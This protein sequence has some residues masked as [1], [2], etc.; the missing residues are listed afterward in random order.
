RSS[1]LVAV[2]AGFRNIKHH[3]LWIFVLEFGIAAAGFTK[4]K[5]E[6]SARLLDTLA[7]C[8]GVVHNKTKVMRT[9]KISTLQFQERQI[10]H[11]IGQIHSRACIQR[12]FAHFLEP[13][14]LLVELGSGFKVWDA[15]RNVTEFC[16]D[17]GS[18]FG[19]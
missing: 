7:H 3:T 6:F 5:Q 1:D 2:P 14:N 19:V 4:A 12:L 17:E 8:F 16:H 9:D 18:L 13:E 11:T 10:Y 15:K